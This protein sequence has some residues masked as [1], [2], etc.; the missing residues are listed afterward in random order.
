M[1][2]RRGC[3]KKDG[4]AAVE[5]STVERSGWYCMASQCF[6]KFLTVQCISVPSLYFL[7]VAVPAVSG[8]LV[9]S[10]AASSRGIQD[11][12]TPS[13]PPLR[14]CQQDCLEACAK[15]ARKIEMACGTGKTRVMKELVGNVSG[16]LLGA[17]VCQ[18]GFYLQLSM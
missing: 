14:K 15:G 1:M 3:V 4:S 12:A 2:K 17:C 6:I 9:A 8:R 13:D 18:V 7:R 16:K 5:D 11:D 10:G